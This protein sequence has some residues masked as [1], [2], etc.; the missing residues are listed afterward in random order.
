MLTPLQG[1][2]LHNVLT[3]SM[4]PYAIVLTLF[5]SYGYKN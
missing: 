5:Q 4:L 3:H 2:M 1:F